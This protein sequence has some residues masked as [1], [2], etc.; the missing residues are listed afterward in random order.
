MHIGDLHWKIQLS[1][2]K[3]SVADESFTTAR[4]E[5]ISRARGPSFIVLFTSK[6]KIIFPYQGHN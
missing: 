1:L 2:L 3:L 5:T 4:A 6:E